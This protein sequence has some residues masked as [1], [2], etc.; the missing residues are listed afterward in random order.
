MRQTSHKYSPKQAHTS[1][2]K[3]KRLPNNPGTR[4]PVK[5]SLHNSEKKNFA[6]FSLSVVV[7]SHSPEV[8]G[9]LSLAASI[10]RHLWS[11]T[12]TCSHAKRKSK[13][14]NSCTELGSANAYLWR[15]LSSRSMTSLLAA[16]TIGFMAA[17]SLTK[18]IVQTIQG[19][20]PRDTKK[21]R[22]TTVL[23][24]PG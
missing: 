9:L 20:P 7:V 21:C 3:C 2:N 24:Q 11:C 13:A 18:I 22:A 5:S 6:D 17:E 1:D 23:G 15:N 16:H 8:T 14:Y 4:K 12:N 10:L 19:C